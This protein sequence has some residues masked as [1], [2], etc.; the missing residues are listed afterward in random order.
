[1]HF[2]H[3]FCFA[4]ISDTSGA[5]GAFDDFLMKKE[6]FSYIVQLVCF[7]L[8]PDMSGAFGAFGAFSVKTIRFYL[9]CADS[10]CALLVH[11]VL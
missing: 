1:M 6:D 5:F 8:T 3:F 10:T 7:E 2:V 11:L 4:L 9:S